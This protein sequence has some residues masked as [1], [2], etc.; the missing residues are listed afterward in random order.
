MLYTPQQLLFYAFRH[1][2]SKFSHLFLSLS[3]PHFT[4]AQNKFAKKIVNWMFLLTFIQKF[5]KKLSKNSKKNHQSVSINSGTL[6]YDYFLTLR[7]AIWYS[8]WYSTPMKL[9]DNRFYANLP[10][11]RFIY[12]HHRLASGICLQTMSKNLFLMSAANVCLKLAKK[13]VWI[14][15][16]R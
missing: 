9:Y 15:Q 16:N 14:S 12:N 3:L 5:L 6:K 11:L 13:N 1:L 2:S 7:T 4:S 10:F 8:R